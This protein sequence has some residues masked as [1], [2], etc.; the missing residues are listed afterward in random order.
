MLS[1]SPRA[2][3]TTN[4]AVKLLNQ[5]HIANQ[6]RYSLH[7]S[8]SFVIFAYLFKNSNKLVLQ[9]RYLPL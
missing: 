7:V 8:T 9:L 2:K 6:Y 4:N 1:G 5:M 3:T